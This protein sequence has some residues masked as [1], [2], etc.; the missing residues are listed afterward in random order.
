MSFLIR[1]DRLWPLQSKMKGQ[2]ESLHLRNE[3]WENF[4]ITVLKLKLWTV[5]LHQEL[6][7]WL[8]EVWLQK[9]KRREFWGDGILWNSA[10][11]GSYINL[12]LCQKSCNHAP[13]NKKKAYFSACKLKKK[14]DNLKLQNILNFKVVRCLASDHNFVNGS[15]WVDGWNWMNKLF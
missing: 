7:E 6:S 12:P 1:T 15:Q 11:R 5:I 4:L 8:G 9:G 14:K 13:K 3:E 2:R 10:W